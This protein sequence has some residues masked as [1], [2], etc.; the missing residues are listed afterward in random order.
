MIKL[1]FFLRL[2]KVWHVSNLLP[3]TLVL[4][5]GEKIWELIFYLLRT[6]C[7]HLGSFCVVSSSLRLG[8]ISPLAFFRWLTYP[9]SRLITWRKPEVK[10]GRN[11]VKK[12][13]YKNYQDE[14]KK[15]AINKKINSQIKKPHLKMIPINGEKIFQHYFFFCN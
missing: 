14:D 2:I 3:Y 1:W 7:P 10:F 15:S 13:Q 9:R 12:N 11:V 6:F 5:T 4:S 8:Q